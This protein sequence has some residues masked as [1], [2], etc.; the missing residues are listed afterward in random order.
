MGGGGGTEEGEKNREK[1]LMNRKLN[2]SNEK[3]NLFK[4]WPSER[5]TE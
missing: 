1:K 3:L 2:E 5:E 4:K